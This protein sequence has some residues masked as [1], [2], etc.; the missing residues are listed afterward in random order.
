MES[1]P[2][3]RHVR[4]GRRLRP[5]DNDL[6][7]YGSSVVAVRASTGEVVWHFNTVINDYWDFD[8]PSQPV[9]ADIEIDGEWVPVVI[10][11]T[12][13]GF[14]F[15]LHRDTGEP[16]VDV[17]YRPV[18]R[19]GPLE[20][21]LSPVQPFPPEAFQ[22]SRSYE[23]G[24][25]LFGFCDDLENESVIGPV[26]TPIT[27]D[28]TIGLP[29]N[30]GA[31]NWGGVAV[32]PERGLIAVRTSS[33][34]FRTK[35]IERAD[36]ADL[37]AI[38]DAEAATSQARTQ[39]QKA[40]FERYNLP[41]GTEVAR[42]SGTDYLMAR[43]VMLDPVIG[44]PCAGV[45]LGE[46]MMIDI[47]DE[48]VLWRRPHGTARDAGLPFNVGMPGV[49]GSLITSSGLVFVGGIAESAFRAYDVT[50]G[51]ELWHHRLPNP[52]NATPMSYTVS[53][54]EG[55]KPFVVVAAGGDERGGIGGVGDYLV[56]FSIAR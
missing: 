24:G 30:M 48:Q 33:V 44:L 13:M 2:A 22:A 18:P 12:K 8:I 56:A 7:Y 21:L 50:T 9:I 53:L 6:S 29:S 55:Q 51:E 16:V 36:A 27:E 17:T 37:L 19:H 20:A 23:A 43:H 42:Q 41:P 45:P 49:G 39:A 11:S 34:P 3:R 31:T 15:V 40:F 32:D 14:V 47:D 1:R 52:A 28:W 5:L 25:S 35:L 26:Y 4:S 10:Q 54:P 46:L 38:L